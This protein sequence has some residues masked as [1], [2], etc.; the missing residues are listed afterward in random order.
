MRTARRCKSHLRSAHAACLVFFYATIT[1][2]CA[3]THDVLC[4]QGSGIAPTYLLNRPLRR[5]RTR[6]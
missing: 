4:V 5:L 1:L 6:G 3:Q 2:C